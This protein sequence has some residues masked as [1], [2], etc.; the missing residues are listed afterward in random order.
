MEATYILHIFFMVGINV[1]QNSPQLWNKKQYRCI[2]VCVC[3]VYLYA[4]SNSN[5]MFISKCGSFISKGGSWKAILLHL[6]CLA[7]NWISFFLFF[8]S[9]LTKE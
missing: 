9:A 4:Y 2:G 3:G 8:T 7:K 1:Q 5:V 6:R